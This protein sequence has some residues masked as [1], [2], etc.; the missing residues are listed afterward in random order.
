MQKLLHQETTVGA[1]LFHIES[2]EVRLF[3]LDAAQIDKHTQNL[4]QSQQQ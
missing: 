2:E 3:Q 1:V 4:T